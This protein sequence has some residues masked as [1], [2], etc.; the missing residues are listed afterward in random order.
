[1]SH[2]GE[3]LRSPA[4]SPCGAFLFGRLP[5]GSRAAGV[6]YAPAPLRG[7]LAPPPAGAASRVGLGVARPRCPR[8]APRQPAPAPP[9]P[10]ARRLFAAGSLRAFGSAPPLRSLRAA[11]ASCSR[12]AGSLRCARSPLR[13]FAPAPLLSSWRLQSLRAR[14][15]SASLASPCGVGSGPCGGRLPRVGSLRGQ[16]GRSVSFAVH[17]CN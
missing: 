12:R 13:A 15:P 7:V 5:Y 14:L 11:V 8:P 17:I 2:F 9:R 16:R 3:C 4:G 10:R 6:R 1:M